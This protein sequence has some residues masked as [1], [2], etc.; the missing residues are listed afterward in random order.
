MTTTSPDTALV[1]TPD[2]ALWPPIEALRQRYDRQASV[3]M[4]HITLLYPFRPRAQFETLAGPLEAVCAQHRPFTLTLE[5]LDVF[6]HDDGQRT[7][8]LAP[9]P[10]A[11]LIALQTALWQAVPDCDDTRRHP[12]GFVPHLT[13]G[14]APDQ[15]AGEQLLA[16]M[17]Q[18]WRPVHFT[19]R[20]VAMIARAGP[21]AAFRPVRHLRLLASP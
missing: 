5:R 20:S 17:C 13:V 2:A 12:G 16:R 14:Q 19:V 21:R 4:P 11:P 7:L 10:A 9:E 8:W 18:T 6:A 1:I 3:V 15:T